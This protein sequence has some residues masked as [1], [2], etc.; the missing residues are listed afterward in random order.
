MRTKLTL[1][2]VGL[3]ATIAAAPA[4]AALDE[5]G[6]AAVTPVASAIPLHGPVR[7]R[8]HLER[9]RRRSRRRC[10]HLPRR[11]PSPRIASLRDDARG[12]P[13]RPQR[14]RPPL[15]SIRIQR[16]RQGRRVSRGRR[17]RRRSWRAGAAAQPDPR[18]VP[19]GVRR[20]GRR[21]RRGRLRGGARRHSGRSGKDPRD[22]GRRGRRRGRPRPARRGRRGHAAGRS[23]TTHRARTPASTASHPAPRS[24][25]HRAGRK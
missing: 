11:Q 14:D 21:E 1:L 5:G 10:L 19:G 7:C 18:T 13:R 23:P 6:G 16:T 9:K 2:A 20:G 12:H 24:C 25:S 17:G 4:Q 22:R 3:A 8:H 15:A